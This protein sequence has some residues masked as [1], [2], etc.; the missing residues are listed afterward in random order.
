MKMTTP[1]DSS[2]MNDTGT[3]FEESF[4]D[5]NCPICHGVGFYVKDVPV[6]HPDFGK[7]QPC[8]CALPKIQAQRKR[9]MNA[10]GSM[11]MLERMTFDTFHPEGV[12]LTPERRKTVRA[13]YE[14]A[15]RFAEHPQ[16]WLLLSGGYGVGKTHLAAAIGNEV[17]ARG[18]EALFV[19]TPDLL[20][21]LRA[22]FS[23]NSPETYDELFDRLKN[24][25]L[26]ILDDLRAE[27]ATPWAQE[28][29]FQLL[30]HR[31]LRRLPTVITTNRPLSALE[32]RLRSRLMDVDLVEQHR[33]LAPD[34]RG[35]GYIDHL[36]EL[37]ELHL[38]E[39]QTFETFLIPTGGRDDLRQNLINVRN[40]AIRYAERPQGW[41]TFIGRSGVGKTHLAAA[42]ANQVRMFQPEVLFISV[43]RLM[44]FLRATMH[45]NADLS[46]LVRFEQIKEAPMLILDDLTPRM[47]SVWAAEKLFQLVDYRYLARKPTVYTITTSDKELKEL[48]NAAPRIFTRLADDT[49][50]QIYHIRSSGRP[51]GQQRLT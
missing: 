40:A 47:S 35:G 33:I 16:G 7:A 37:S 11:E 44:D 45:A 42:I 38:H 2:S 4:G 46:L 30:N 27:S 3:A 14:A 22:S 49:F 21:H 31:Y 10:L 25:P 19:L 43:P 18:G 32:A 28:K 36:V 5:P 24:T 26:L 39:H 13:A 29:L 50:S 6:G 9:Q 8:R 1:S 48:Q 20:D 34:Y 15:R 12:G 51:R 23:P 17:I 41:M